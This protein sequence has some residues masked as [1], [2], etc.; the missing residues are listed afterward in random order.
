MIRLIKRFSIKI[1]SFLKNQSES[2]KTDI[3]ILAYGMEIAIRTIIKIFMTVILSLILQIFDTTFICILNFVIF[4]IIGGGAHLD[5]YLGC[6]SLS[7]IIFLI[8]GKLSKINISSDILMIL[9]LLVILFGLYVTIKYVPADTE[10]RRITNSK[11]IIKAKR[12]TLLVLVVWMIG[13]MML[14]KKLYISFATA[15]ILGTLISFL[16]MT[17]LGYAIIDRLNS[18]FEWFKTL[19]FLKER[20]RK[21]C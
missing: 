13:I 10:K 5:T 8:I 17:A 12:N 21:G 6:L 2:E 1:A 3:E 14:I 11:K 4:R 7:I 20:R 19:S 9:L 16:F 15:S 18:F